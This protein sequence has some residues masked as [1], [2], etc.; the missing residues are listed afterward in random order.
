MGEVILTGVLGPFNEEV[1]FRFLL[2]YFLPYSFFYYIFE[3][4]C[5]RRLVFSRDNILIKA[6]KERNKGIVIC[7]VILLSSLFSIV[8]GPNFLSFP[9]YFLGGI[10]FSYLFLRFGFLPAWIAHGSY[11]ILSPY[12]HFIFIKIIEI[13]S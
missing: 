11:N 10:I 12:V 7:W 4:K 8:H 3:E 6:F 1:I 5:T 9:M 13:S 2:L